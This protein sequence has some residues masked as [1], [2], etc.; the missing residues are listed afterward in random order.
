MTDVNEDLAPRKVNDV[1]ADRN[2]EAPAPVG[3]GT[4]VE[5]I[6][7]A[8]RQACDYQEE[9]EGLAERGDL[10]RARQ[11]LTALSKARQAYR[12][13]CSELGELGCRL[14]DERAGAV[15]F[16]AI[17]EGKWVELYWRLGED[18]ISRW[19]DPH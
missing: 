18:Q 6:Q 11:T 19:H 12:A 13:F 16:P 1:L 9:F 10:E 14:S 3:D 15:D 4:I 2:N 5:D 8:S 17:V 7:E